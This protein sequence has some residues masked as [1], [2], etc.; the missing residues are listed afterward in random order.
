MAKVNATSPKMFFK[1]LS[2]PLDCSLTTIF[3][4]TIRP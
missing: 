2:L 3:N 1:G 4:F